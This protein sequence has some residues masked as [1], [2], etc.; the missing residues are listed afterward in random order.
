MINKVYMKLK[1]KINRSFIKEHFKI[2]KMVRSNH[3]MQ[4]NS[5]NSVLQICEINMK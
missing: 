2:E 3:M 4:D 1:I 5:L